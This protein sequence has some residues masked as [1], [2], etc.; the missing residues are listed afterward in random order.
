[1][2]VRDR[3]HLA[4]EDV[5]PGDKDPDGSRIVLELRIRGRPRHSAH[6][7]HN[8]PRATTNWLSILSQSVKECISHA[9]SCCE[10]VKI[11]CYDRTECYSRLDEG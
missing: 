7:K 10:K 1:M 4:N 3:V 9:R 5:T 11:G 6:F 8:G 2:I